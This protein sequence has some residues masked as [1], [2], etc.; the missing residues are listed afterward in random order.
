MS[1]EETYEQFCKDIPAGRIPLGYELKNV[2]KISIPFAQLYCASLYFGNPMGISP[3]LR[4]FICAA[5]RNGMQITL[6]KRTKNSAFDGAQQC[7]ND[8]PNVKTFACTNEASLELCDMLIGEIK[9]RKVFRNEYCEKNGIAAGLAKQPETVKKASP[10]IR[11]HTKPALILIEDFHEFSA[12]LSNT[13]QNTLK[14]IFAHGRGY[15][16]YFISCFY[17]E[18]REKLSVDPLAKSYAEDSL[19]L[20]FGGQFQNQTLTTLPMEYRKITEPNKQYNRFLLRYNGS[21]YPLAMPC[22]PLQDENIDPDERP[23]I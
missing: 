4:N 21:F 17:P 8:C 9:Q 19:M 23:I 20:F 16:F 7:M 15:N 18:H 10:Y 5:K 13:A 12:N 11:Q 6:V 1:E 22:G 2:E 14:D 3:V